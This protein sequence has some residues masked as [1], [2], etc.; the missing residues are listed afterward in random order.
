LDQHTVDAP[1]INA[2]KGRLDKLKHTRMDLGFLWTN[3]H[4]HWPYRMTDSPVR[5]YKVRTMF[6][7]L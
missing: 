7:Y 1:I 2:F 5:P 3:A 6:Y 4:S